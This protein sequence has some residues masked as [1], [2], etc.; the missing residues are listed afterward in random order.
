V[1]Q[2]DSLLVFLFLI[3]RIRSWLSLQVSLMST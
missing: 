2:Q 3:R 1:G